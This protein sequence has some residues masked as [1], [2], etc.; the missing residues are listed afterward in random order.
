MS[1]LLKLRRGETRDLPLKIETSETVVLIG[2]C[3]P[4]LSE[5][6]LHSASSDIFFSCLHWWQYPYY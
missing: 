1:F 4:I 6:Y 3:M 2:D 5:S